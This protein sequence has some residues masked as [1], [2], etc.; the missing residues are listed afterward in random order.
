MR[1][2]NQDPEPLCPE[3]YAIRIVGDPCLEQI[4]AE[5]LPGDLAIATEICRMHITL[6]NFRTTHGYGRGLAAPQ[7]GIGK[8]IIVMNLGA[9]P[10]VLINPEI[11]WRSDD[12]FEVWDDCLSVP[13]RVVRVRR[14]RSISVRYLDE[15]R[16]WRTWTRLPSNLSELVQHEVDHL[17]G[18]LMLKRAWGDDAV[19]PIEQHANLVGAVRPKHRLSLAQIMKAAEA[20]DPIFRNSPQFECDSL[21]DA[22]GCRVLLKIETAKPIRSFK[23]RGADF[24]LQEAARSGDQRPLVC[25]SAGN[26]GQA[27]AYA[28]RKQ[29]RRVVVYA[30]QNASPMKLERMR[31]LGADVRLAG[32]DF[33]AAKHEAKRF[34]SVEG[35]SMVEDGKESAISEGAGSIGVELLADY[36]ALDR[37][38]LPLGNGALL[39]G[40]GRWVKAASPPTVVTGV[41]AAGADCMKLSFE[42]GAPVETTSVNTI[43]DGIGV[44][45][46]VPEAVTD[47]RGIVDEVRVVTDDEILRAM[48]LV[49]ACTGLSAEP[50]GVA[51]LAAILSSPSDFSDRNV[52]TVLC[53]SN[54]TR[55]QSRLWLID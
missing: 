16:R 10:F 19:R 37:I 22:L 38:L 18:I 31:R 47:M 5:V 11:T 35:A 26:F 23:G 40:T 15:Q 4:A 14:H 43:A 46:P 32:E 44:R 41:C 3:G 7:V 39:N 17:D 24:F 36:P 25:S 49:F 28:A 1:L 21:N 52:A 9:T 42:R 53:G 8:R 55:D 54:M 34:A 33:D 6:A 13:D 51:G 29:R 2:W 48:R 20:V 45:V 12:L 30:A 27:M 50:A